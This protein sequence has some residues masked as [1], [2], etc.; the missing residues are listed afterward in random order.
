MGETGRVTALKARVD[1]Q[2]KNVNTKIQQAPLL[3][4]NMMNDGHT[5]KSI[6]VEVP[7]RKL[8]PDLKTV[9]GNHI[10]FFGQERLGHD[11][12]KELNV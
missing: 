2:S 5:V 3:L 8:A 7:D 10:D 6:S 4:S 9:G 1:M 11:R 12:C